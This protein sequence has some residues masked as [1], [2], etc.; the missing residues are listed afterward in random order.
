MKTL[1]YDILL[2]NLSNFIY[3]LIQ[4]YVE[5]GCS[6]LNYIPTFSHTIIHGSQTNFGKGQFWKKNYRKDKNNS[7][8]QKD[9]KRES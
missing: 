1:S 6:S 5:K 3:V 2:Y 7:A 8:Y 4:R 9:E